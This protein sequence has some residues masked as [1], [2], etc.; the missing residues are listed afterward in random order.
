[1][2]EVRCVK[3]VATHPQCT[4]GLDRRLSAP[5]KPNWRLPSARLIEARYPRATARS[6]PVCRFKTSC[7][8][9]RITVSCQWRR[10]YLWDDGVRFGL[11]LGVKV[12]LPQVYV[13]KRLVQLAVE[14]Q[15]SSTPLSKPT[16]KSVSLLLFI[17]ARVQMN[18]REMSATYCLAPVLPF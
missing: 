4:G 15:L 9:C 3:V 7:G 16:L 12:V 5:L 10:S 2:R 11:G 1:M 17:K 6:A 8:V 13:E 14:H 18:V